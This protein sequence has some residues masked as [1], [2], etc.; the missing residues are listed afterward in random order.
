MKVIRGFA[1]ADALRGCA[2]A[3]GNFDGVHLGH[4]RL[5]ETAR[6]RASTHR[7][8]AVALTFDPHPAR[9]LRPR[10]APPILTP[11]RSPNPSRS[12]RDGRRR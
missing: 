8:P 4:R 6:A 3:I 9:V 7:S 1:G 5:L 2:V 12:S 11:P 10:M